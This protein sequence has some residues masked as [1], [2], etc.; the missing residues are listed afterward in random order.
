[1]A[2]NL[3]GLAGKTK[4]KNF[5]FPRRHRRHVVTENRPLCPLLSRPAGPRTRLEGSAAVFTMKGM[6]HMKENGT[7]AVS[8]RRAASAQ[9][10]QGLA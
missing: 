8:L 1:M 6:K 4:V 7:P 5:I 9:L 2:S 3:T 10:R